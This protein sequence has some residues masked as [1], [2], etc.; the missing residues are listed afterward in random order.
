MAGVA[1]EFP[2][3]LIVGL[4]YLGV[5]AV[6]LT[7]YTFKTG[8]LFSKGK[9]PV[10]QSFILSYGVSLILILIYIAVVGGF[11]NRKAAGY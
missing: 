4:V 9:R 1:I 5:Y 3:G 10:L 6:P 11:K 8:D 2:S 7:V